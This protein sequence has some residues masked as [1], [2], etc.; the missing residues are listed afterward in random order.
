MK[1]YLS[2]L[3]FLLFSSDIFAAE[4]L[5]ARGE[6][7]HDFYQADFVYFT[8]DTGQTAVNCTDTVVMTGSEYESLNEQTDS[9]NAFDSEAFDLGQEAMIKMFIVGF[10][11]GAI[12][13]MLMKLRR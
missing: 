12:I 7:F 10:G 1:T 6:Y 5:Q 3:I 9:D 8:R 4:C 2:A 13:A 11:I